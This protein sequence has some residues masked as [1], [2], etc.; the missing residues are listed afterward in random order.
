[1]KESHRSLRIERSDDGLV[2]VVLTGPGKGNTMGPDYWREMPEVFTA[3]DADESVRAIIVRG[4]G[5]NF[6]YG[7]DLMAMSAE[8]G[9]LIQGDNLAAARTRLLDLIE[10]FQQACDRVARCRH[11]VI[12]ALHGWCVGGGLDLAAACDI[13][14][15]SS[16]AKISL[17]EV[18]VAM[19]ADV[20]SLQ[21]LPRIIGEAHT[22]EL[23]YTGRDIDSARALRIGLVTDVYDTPEDLLREARAL[24]RAIAANP[25]LVVQGIKQ[26]IDYCADKSLADGLRFV[27]VWNAAFLQSNDL[28]EAMAAFV[29]KR[30]AAF[31]GQ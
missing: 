24:A 27:A 7:L 2:E 23:A 28:G 14:L 19:V 3:L 8:L 15:A 6:S 25:P 18:K 1:M 5:K 26:V 30:P 4:D 13:R 16:D 12:A 31:K 29:E 22:R 17:R 10:R 11:P 20:G 9:P 21:R